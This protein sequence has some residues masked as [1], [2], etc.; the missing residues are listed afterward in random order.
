MLSADRMRDR[1]AAAGS[2]PGRGI[3]PHRDGVGEGARQTEPRPGPDFAADRRSSAANDDLPDP[4]EPTMATRNGVPALAVAEQVLPGVRRRPNGQGCPPRTR[5]A[6]RRAGSPG[7]AEAGAVSRVAASG[8]GGYDSTA[9][10]LTSVSHYPKLPSD[11][12]PKPGSPSTAGLVRLARRSRGRAPAMRRLV[13]GA[14]GCYLSAD[15]HVRFA[16]HNG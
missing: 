14:V 6:G 1:I 2:R 16:S 4:A 15:P 13:S 5:R 9:D 12:L 8:A 11:R 7:L 3:D 10:E